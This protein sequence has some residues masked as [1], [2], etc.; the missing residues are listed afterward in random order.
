MSSDLINNSSMKVW[1]KLCFYSI[2]RI[3]ESTD[4][5]HL[6]GRIKVML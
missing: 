4:E 3:L 1:A 2:S 6:K 5:V